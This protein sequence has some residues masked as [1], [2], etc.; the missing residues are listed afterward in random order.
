MHDSLHGLL[1]TCFEAVELAFNKRLGCFA[2]LISP[3]PFLSCC[4]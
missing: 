4:R 2:L 1:C 3:S